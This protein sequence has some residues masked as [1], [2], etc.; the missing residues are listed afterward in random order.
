MKFVNTLLDCINECLFFLNRF[1]YKT[2][3]NIVRYITDYNLEEK[4]KK[5]FF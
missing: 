3:Y 1:F 5:M 4:E 2:Q